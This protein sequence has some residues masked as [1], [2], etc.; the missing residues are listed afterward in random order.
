MHLLNR[1][2]VGASRPAPRSCV[3]AGMDNPSN[4]MNC[5]IAKTRDAML[6]IDRGV[7]QVYG[8]MVDLSVV[9]DISDFL[10]QVIAAMTTIDNNTRNA[11]TAPTAVIRAVA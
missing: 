1:C 11:T 7:N 8:L 4:E 9:D 5:I 6:A 2:R 10:P 3:G